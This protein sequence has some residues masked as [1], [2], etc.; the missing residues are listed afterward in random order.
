MI[1]V[2]PRNRSCLH[3][4]SLCTHLLVANIQYMRGPFGN[5]V[6]TLGRV[7]RAKLEYNQHAQ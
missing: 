1:I 7:D 6:R 2:L 5:T 3:N 4:L